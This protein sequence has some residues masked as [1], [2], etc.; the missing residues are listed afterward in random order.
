MSRNN[1]AVKSSLDYMNTE[2]SFLLTA[3]TAP[4]YSWKYYEASNA[5]GYGS[6]PYVDI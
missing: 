5:I 3:Y 4:Y 2:K 6:E 1:E